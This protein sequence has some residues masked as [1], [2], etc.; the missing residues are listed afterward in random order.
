MS[1]TTRKPE[2]PNHESRL[3]LHLSLYKGPGKGRVLAGPMAGITP[4]IGLT[5]LSK[6]QKGRRLQQW[7]RRNHSG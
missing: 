3:G 1:Q 4:T 6:S 2:S 5:M 7:Q